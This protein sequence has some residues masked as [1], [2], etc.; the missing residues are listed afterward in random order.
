MIF[1]L[2]I[3]I[4]LILL[5]L[6]LLNYSLKYVFLTIISYLQ[7]RT[8]QDYHNGHSMSDIP[9]EIKKKYDIIKVIGEGNFAV[10]YECIDKYVI[11]INPN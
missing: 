9:K 4:F 10:V 2:K 3:H 11:F 7:S 1:I 8:G 6:Y 5:K